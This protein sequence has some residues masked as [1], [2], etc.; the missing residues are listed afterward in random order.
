MSYEVDDAL[1][2]PLPTDY[3]GGLR[4][5]L[6]AL[7]GAYNSNQRLLG[8]LLRYFVVGSI[9]TIV[10]NASVLYLTSVRHTEALLAS[11]IAFGVSVPFSYSGH[12]IHTF[13]SNAG[14][15][16]EFTRFLIFS[17]F[18]LVIAVLSMFILVTL[19]GFPPIVGSFTATIV[20]P[21]VN[22]LLLNFKVFRQLGRS[23]S[24]LV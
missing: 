14:V 24:I 21:M 11:V 18:S 17:P 15:G 12:R 19:I 4:R 3:L 9:V 8:K 2:S 13:K 23:K 22:F 1:D 6:P 20:A 16:R 10:Y 5:L 7:F